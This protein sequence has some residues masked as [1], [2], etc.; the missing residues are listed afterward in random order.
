MWTHN[1]H[2]AV[3]ILTQ[4]PSCRQTEQIKMFC[5]VEINLPNPTWGGR[6]SDNLRRPLLQRNG[7]RSCK[8]VRTSPAFSSGTDLKLQPAGGLQ[9]ATPTTDIFQSA[10]NALDLVSPTESYDPDYGEHHEDISLE[11][12][13]AA[14]QV[15]KAVY[16]VGS[17]PV[18][19]KCC[20]NCHHR[21]CSDQFT[22]G[23]Q[24]VK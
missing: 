18:L 2:A 14:A 21:K 20:L 19:V 17:I 16:E 10:L 5:R 13:Q 7:F 12:G 9:D 11:Q 4:V 3:H 22:T 23:A 1:P 6:L 24:A 8:G 15:G